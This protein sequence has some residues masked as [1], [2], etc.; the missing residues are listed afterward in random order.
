MF[1]LF[2]ALQLQLERVDPTH[3]SGN[4]QV[5]GEKRASGELD[6][7]VCDALMLPY[8][9]TWFSLLLIRKQFKYKSS[10]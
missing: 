6:Y 4:E 5:R 7:K 3:T 1:L 8:F 2:G 10:V 9:Y